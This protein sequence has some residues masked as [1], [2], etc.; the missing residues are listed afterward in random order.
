M[1]AVD[2]AGGT[3]KATTFAPTTTGSCLALTNSNYFTFTTRPVAG[4]V[5]CAIYRTSAPGSYPTGLLDYVLCGSAFFDVGG[6]PIGPAPQTIDSSGSMNASG[7]LTAATFQA[8]GAASSGTS[9]WMQG[10]QLTGCGTALSPLPPPCIPFQGAFFLN[11]PGS[12][13]SSYGWTAPGTA[14]SGNTLL[15][16]GPPGTPVGNVAASPLGYIT[17]DTVTTHALFATAGAPAFRALAGSDLPLPSS[18][19]LGGVESI[20][21]VP[22]NFLTGIA[23]SGVPSVAQPN[24]SDLN[25]TVVAPL[26]LVG[27]T[28]AIQ[29]SAST[30]VTT[31]LGTD[32]AYFTASGSASTSGNM[33]VGDTSGGIKDSGTSAPVGCTTSCNFLLGAPAVVPPLVVAVGGGHAVNATNQ[34]YVVSFYNDITRKVGNGYVYVGG[35]ASSGNVSEGLY[36]SAGNRAW[37]TGGIS[38]LTAGAVSFSPTA[39]TMKPGF[40]YIAY[41]ASPSA[42]TAVLASSVDI[43]AANNASN[44]MAGLPAHKWGTSTDNCSTP[45]AG[46]V[47][48]SITTGNISNSSS[49]IEIAAV[50]ITN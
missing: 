13:T 49:N 41:C 40:Y 39:Y 48:A 37:W 24:L 45:T 29:N 32:T 26:A 33:I 42:A 34:L 25:G 17:T 9:I 16:L 7:N 18:T 36:D 30:N 10:G 3:T 6:T 47:P 5:K 28:L 14:N 1:A 12:I 8:T 44:F 2:S 50:M 11:A 21:P 19:T 35:A 20:S 46:N 23:T 38:T 4:A 22:H 27:N 31:A 15:Y 43:G